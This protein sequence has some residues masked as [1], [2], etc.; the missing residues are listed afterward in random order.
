MEPRA[1]RKTWLVFRSTKNT[2]VALGK[3]SGVLRLFNVENSAPCF[4]G[5]F[6]F[7]FKVCFRFFWGGGW[8][9]GCKHFSHMMSVP[10]ALV[11]DEGDAFSAGKILHK[12]RLDSFVCKPQVKVE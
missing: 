1:S 3:T 6:G 5:S 8:G 7:F 11:D 10:K 4:L 9:G 2:L 12:T